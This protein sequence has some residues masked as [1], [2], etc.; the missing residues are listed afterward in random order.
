MLHSGFQQSACLVPA[1]CIVGW[2]T[3]HS[4]FEHAAYWVRECVMVGSPMLHGRLGHDACSPLRAA[5]WLHSAAWSGARVCKVD[6]ES[7]KVE[8]TGVHSRLISVHSRPII[9]QRHAQG[10]H[11]HLGRSLGPENQPSFRVLLCRCFRHAKE[12]SPIIDDTWPLLRDFKSD[13]LNRHGEHE[14]RRVR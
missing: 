8:S 2:S 4:R 10:D 5:R 9:R 6:S 13:C 14:K 7:C 1:I 3:L 11:G 12:Q